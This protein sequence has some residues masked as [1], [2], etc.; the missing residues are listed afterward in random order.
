[1]SSNRYSEIIKR[2]VFI[3]SSYAKERFAN[4]NSNI[5]KNSQKI[6]LFYFLMDSRQRPIEIHSIEFQFLLRKLAPSV[7]F[8]NSFFISLDINHLE[9][10][11]ISNKI[12]LPHC[13]SLSVL[14]NTLF[15][16]SVCSICNRH[17]LL[18]VGSKISSVLY[19]FRTIP[20]T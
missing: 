15:I 17:Y 18:F 12:I 20:W 19:A 5:I 10:Q 13:Q 6:D 4:S 14:F 2:Y 16:T 9:F 7:F 8:R 3:F 1:M 11:T